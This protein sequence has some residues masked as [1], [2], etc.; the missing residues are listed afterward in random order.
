M[1]TSKKQD[2]DKFVKDQ[3]DICIYFGHICEQVQHFREVFYKIFLKIMEENG[4]P[5]STNQTISLLR[6]IVKGVS[7]KKNMTD[8][9]RYLFAQRTSG[10]WKK[11]KGDYLICT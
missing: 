1:A 11:A 2:F 5:L 8:E 6:K 3:I 10:V 7:E 4:V 9:E